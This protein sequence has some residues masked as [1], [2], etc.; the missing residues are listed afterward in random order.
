MLKWKK[1]E[2]STCDVWL[3]CLMALNILTKSRPSLKMGSVKNPI[4]WK[5]SVEPVLKEVLKQRTFCRLMKK[6]FPVIDIHDEELVLAHDFVSSIMQWDQT[7]RPSV[8]KI[9]GHPERFG[10]WRQFI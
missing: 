5:V 1:V 4:D 2:G 3:L 10:N 8:R 7:E 9:L 6:S